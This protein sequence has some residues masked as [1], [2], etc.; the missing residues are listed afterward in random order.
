MYRKNLACTRQLLLAANDLLV[1]LF[2]DGKI[3]FLDISKYLKKTV[4]L[5]EFNKFKHILP[6]NYKSDN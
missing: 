2:L 4:K 6:T 5:K 1:D 3:K